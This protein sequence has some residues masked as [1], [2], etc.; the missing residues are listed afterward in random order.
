[1]KTIEEAPKETAGQQEAN[2]G[3]TAEPGEQEAFQGPGK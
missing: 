2:R 3:T 1:V